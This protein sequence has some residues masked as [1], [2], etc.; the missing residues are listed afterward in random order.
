MGEGVLLE[1]CK[2]LA[3]SLGI[4]QNIDFLGA[5]S[6][7]EVAKNLSIARA[8]VQHS[9]KPSYGDSEGTSISVVEACAMGI[10]VVSTRHG[11]IKDVIIENE[12]GFLVD[13]GDVDGMAEYM[14]Q[15]AENPELAKK[16]GE[17]GREIIKNNFSQDKYIGNIWTIIKDSIEKNKAQQLTQK[18]NLSE[19]NLIVFPDWSNYEEEIG[20]ELLEVI[21]QLMETPPEKPITLLVDITGILPEDAT[22]LFS[23]ISMSLLFEYELDLTEYINISLLGDLTEQEWQILTPLITKKNKN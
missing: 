7:Q 23:A 17:A 3:K 11:G 9:L 5:V 1:S 16:M 12:T 6:H 20:E 13:E 14:I 21:L 4:E 10:P 2:I 15:L 18:L 19:S 8:F 22:E